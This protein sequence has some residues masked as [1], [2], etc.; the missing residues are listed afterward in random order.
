MTGSISQPLSHAGSEGTCIVDSGNLLTVAAYENC[1]LDYA[2]ATAESNESGDRPALSEFL[3]A[4]PPNCR[5]LEIG[6]GPGWDAD[7]I[8][9]AGMRVRR[10]DAAKAFVDFQR[11]RGAHAELLDVVNDE[12]EGPYD[13]VIALYVFQHIERAVLPCVL[14][15]VSAA[16]MD[17]GILLF[18]IRE[19][20]GDFVEHGETSGCYFIAMWRQSEL[21]TILASLGLNLT[22]SNS[23]AD[24][25]GRWL[26]ML[27]A[28]CS[29]NA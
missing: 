24:Q 9:R 27:L 16:L 8:E 2:H 23:H 5:V 10:T 3:K 18:S 1:A 28:K 21:T 4:A 14:A 12:L 26:T 7:R 25:D 22:W 17:R 15:K 11:A 20:I 19:G 6:S 29:D 13:A